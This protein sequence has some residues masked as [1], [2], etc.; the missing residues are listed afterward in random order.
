MNRIIVIL[1]CILVILSAIILGSV[2][3]ENKQGEKI[4]EISNKAQVSDKVTDDC[5]EEYEEMQNQENTLDANSKEEIKLSPNCS[6]IIKTHYIDCDHT[7]NQ[8]TNLPEKLVNKTE[9]EFKKEY[10]DYKIEK[11]TENEVIISKDINGECNEHYIVRTVDGKLTVF[12]I[13]RGIEELYEQTEI[14][15]EYMTE[16][17]KIQFENGLKVYGKENLSQLLEDFE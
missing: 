5:V 1:V 12:R 8:Y 7:S 16:T 11:F 14:S 4:A 13:E 10:P 9:E 6:L 3:Y 15:T 17:D 2:I